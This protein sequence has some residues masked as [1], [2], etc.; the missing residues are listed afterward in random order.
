VVAWCVARPAMLSL[1][2]MQEAATVTV[3]KCSVEF[4]CTQ[5]LLSHRHAKTQARL[6]EFVSEILAENKKR[7]SGEFD[8]RNGVLRLSAK[9]VNGLPPWRG[10]RDDS[11]TPAPPRSPSDLG[12]GAAT[13][14]LTFCSCSCSSLQH[15]VR[16]DWAT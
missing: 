6:S 10:A 8:R 16:A 13:V 11:S 2:M 15:H 14:Q 9:Y 3:Q 5:A 7:F 4:W 12:S 1:C